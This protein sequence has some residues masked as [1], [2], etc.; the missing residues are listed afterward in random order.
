MNSE[1]ATKVAPL[2]D[3]VLLISDELLSAGGTITS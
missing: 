3:L 1:R 2:I